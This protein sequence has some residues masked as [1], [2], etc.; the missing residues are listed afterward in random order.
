MN[1][2]WR[3]I[4][5]MSE[6]SP[7]AYRCADVVE[8]LACPSIS[9][10]PAWMLMS[11]SRVVDVLGDA[12]LDAVDGVDH[13]LGSP[14][15][16]PREWSTRTPVV[17]SNC[18]IVQAGPAELERLVPHHVG[19]AGDGLAVV[20]LAVGPGDEGVAR[21]ADAVRPLPVRR[22]VQED[23]GVGALAA[24]GEVV[25]V[26]ALAPRVSQP[27]TRMLSGS[28]GPS[29]SF[30]PGRLASW[31]VD[32][33]DGDVAV[34]VAVDVGDAQPGD[35][36][37]HQHEMPTA[38]ADGVLRLHLAPALGRRGRPDSAP[39]G[40][41]SDMR[42]QLRSGPSG[43]SGPNADRLSRTVRREVVR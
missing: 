7:T 14:G 36:P 37:Q 12:D 9:R 40:A 25:D 22:E 15:S 16:R 41:V 38:P 29:T 19:A 42:A 34:E 26:V 1:A 6:P 3:L 2:C 23:R 8:R 5:P 10:V 39:S 35:E 21:D 17:C 18:W 20:V 31:L 4:R 11:C 32:V 13:V 33:D 43:E 30:F 28:C 27:I 24:A